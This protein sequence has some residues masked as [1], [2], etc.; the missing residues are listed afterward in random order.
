MWYVQHNFPLGD[1]KSGSYCILYTVCVCVPRL[2]CYFR[3]G[4]ASL[5]LS[6]IQ[7]TILPTD[8]EMRGLRLLDKCQIST[9]ACKIKLL[10]RSTREVRTL[11]HHACISYRSERTHK[12]THTHQFPIIP[13]SLL[14]T[15]VLKAISHFLPSFSSLSRFHTLPL[16]PFNSIQFNSIQLKGF[17]GMGNICLHCQSK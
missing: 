3:S 6:G 13:S 9:W 2:Q 11:C 16:S 4:Q 15:S 1:N 14:C 7:R 10:M 12:H 17:I 5:S 8:G